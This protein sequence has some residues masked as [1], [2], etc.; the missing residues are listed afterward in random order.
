M[1]ANRIVD[2]IFPARLQS[3]EQREA[4]EVMEELS[5][6]VHRALKFMNRTSSTSGTGKAEV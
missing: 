2:P 1:I 5:S 3:K 6:Q 4:V